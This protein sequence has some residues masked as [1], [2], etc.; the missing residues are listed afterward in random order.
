MSV[1]STLPLVGCCQELYC[2]Q[3]ISVDGTLLWHDSILCSLALRQRLQ[4]TSINS[5]HNGHTPQHA[6]SHTA[7]A[8]AISVIMSARQWCLHLSMQEPL[9]NAGLLQAETSKGR[10]GQ[11]Q[12]VC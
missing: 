9:P 12:P 7:F 5:C 4:A 3:T 2:R 11:I 1:V 6:L 10:N 8:S